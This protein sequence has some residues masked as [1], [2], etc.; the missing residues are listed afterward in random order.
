MCGIAGYVGKLQIS[1]DKVSE[2]LELMKRRGPD[3]SGVYRH[4]FSDNRSVCLIHSRLAIIDLDKRADQPFRVGSKVMVYN[5]ELYNYLEVKEHLRSKGY[6]FDTKSDTEVL[7]KQICA[8]GTAGLDKCEGMWS[9]AVYDEKD[10]SILFSRDRFAEKPLYIYETNDGFYFGSEIKFIRALC[11]KKLEVNYNHLYRYL[12]NGYK[13]LY[14]V[15]DTFFKG[16]EEFPSS[17][18]WSISAKGRIE[19]ENY[20][21]HISDIDDSMSYGQAVK[22]AREALIRSVELRLRSDVPLAFCM[23]GGVDSN[24]LISIAKRVFNYDVHGFTIVND[25]QRYDEW[26]LVQNSVKELGIKHT[27]ISVNTSGFLDKLRTLIR[28]HDIPVYTITF[29]AHWLL[30]ESIAE[31]GYKVS[32]SGTAADELF[33]GFYDH[34]S[35][36]LYEVSKNPQFFE[37]SLANWKKHIKPIVRNPVLQDPNVFIAD[38]NE[39]SHIYL[40]AEF[41]ASFLF[42]SFNEGFVENKY[43]DGLLRNRM[44]NELFHESVPVILHE[45]DHNAMYYSI[46]NRSPFLDRSLFDYCYSIP[47]QHLI[48]DGYNKK[49]LRDAMRGVVSDDILNER[50]KIGFN[51]SIYSFLDINDLKVKDF[52]L[53]DGLVFEHIRKEKVKKLISKSYLTNSE[54]KFLFNFICTKIFLEEFA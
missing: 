8:Q 2:C 45:D 3:A 29:Y 16:I 53:G 4:R 40:D 36:Y 47:T 14:K 19:K 12:V 10:G 46:E 1:E 20:W 24:S 5:G 44:Q 13:S 15:K 22:G 6:S 18:A 32:I 31:H 35:M 49:V 25:D 26:D 28:Y 43:C 37:E 39:R 21:N 17:S 33:T 27:S 11:N 54:S 30:M 34:H 9:F 51:A 7:L 41:F 23:S 52:V 42:D 48:G 50:R 38:Q